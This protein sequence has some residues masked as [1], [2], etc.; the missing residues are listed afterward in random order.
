VVQYVALYQ[1]FIDNNITYSG[2]TYPAIPEGKQGLLTKTVGNL[3]TAL[4]NAPSAALRVAADSL[5]GER[6][7]QYIRRN[8]EKQLAQNEENHNFKYSDEQRIHIEQN[9]RQDVLNDNFKGLERVQQIVSTLSDEDFNRLCRYLA[10]P[11]AFGYSSKTAATFYRG[12]EIQRIFR[13]LSNS[14]YKY[15]GLSIQHVKNSYTGALSKI[16]SPYLKS[17]SAVIT[18]NDMLTTGGHNISSRITRV[19]RT[20]GYRHHSHS[21][22]NIPHQASPNTPSASPSGGTP[23]A[24]RV[25]QQSVPRPPQNVKPAVR[26]RAAV[27]PT[28]A[29]SHRGL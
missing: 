14:V 27:I 17:A 22:G 11:R 7:R 9:V 29:R 26:P 2:N 23:P 25:G 5:S 28:A 16:F 21:G 6:F 24:Q 20:K 1:L 8:M 15:L 13:R 18:F 3:L 10:A 19:N 12:Q 4:R